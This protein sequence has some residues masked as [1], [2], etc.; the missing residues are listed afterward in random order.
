[1]QPSQR[2]SFDGSTTASG[3]Y[4]LTHPVSNRDATILF[5][6]QARTTAN[7]LSPTS[8]MAYR[9]VNK[10]LSANSQASYADRW[11][12]DLAVMGNISKMY[13]NYAAQQIIDTM[14]RVAVAINEDGVVNPNDALWQTEH[15]THGRLLLV[16]SCHC[17]AFV[18][19]EVAQGPVRDIIVT[20]MIDANI[21]E[22]RAYELVVT[23]VDNA[24]RRERASSSDEES[25]DYQSPKDL[26]S[27]SVD[28]ASENE[29]PFG[30]A[31][32]YESITTSIL[33]VAT[34]ILN[35]MTT[36][37]WMLSFGSRMKIKLASAGPLI[38]CLH[39]S[40]ARQD[41]WRGTRG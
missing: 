22:A 33:S 16:P 24:Y 28:D 34:A 8:H 21:A 40:T 12:I 14:G 41:I 17:P 2:H 7:T 13:T 36:L 27:F 25:E 39:T 29:E 3:R 20:K 30:E 35:S 38:S 23:A 4:L 26:I 32:S 10:A 5:I 37:S 15:P 11:T 19:A 18:H 6:L 31:S 9:N 1:M